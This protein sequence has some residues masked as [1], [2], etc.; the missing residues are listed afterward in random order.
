M[1]GHDA[2]GNRTSGGWVG[3]SIIPQT[4][5]RW[6][7]LMSS[8]QFFYDRRGSARR[9]MHPLYMGVAET[10]RP[11]DPSLLKI[12]PLKSLTLNQYMHYERH[13]EADKLSTRP[14]AC[15]NPRDSEGPPDRTRQPSLAQ[16]QPS[17]AHT[18]RGSLA[19]ISTRPTACSNPR[20]SEG[21]PDRTRQPSLAQGQPSL[22]HTVRGSLAD[23]STR[24]TACSN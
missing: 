13:L 12:A 9:V 21:P 4:G 17:L 24:P 1:P 5:R 15:S 19:D 10:Y 2:S 18:V 7:T 16:G 20:D 23:I 11:L 6:I 3:D 22:A 8:G 14:T